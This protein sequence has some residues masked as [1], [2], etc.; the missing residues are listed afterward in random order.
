MLLI[1]HFHWLP[2]ASQNRL[3]ICVCVSSS[4]ITK[5][6]GGREVDGSVVTCACCAVGKSAREELIVNDQNLSGR[7]KDEIIQVALSLLQ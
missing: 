4:V 6:V 1:C 7:R 2:V 5:C 3:A